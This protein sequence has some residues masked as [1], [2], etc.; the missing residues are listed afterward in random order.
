MTERPWEL[1]KF[2][3]DA[4]TRAIDG[5]D[6]DH[7]P[8]YQAELTRIEQDCDARYARGQELI[9]ETSVED[10]ERCRRLYREKNGQYGADT[11]CE[12]LVSRKFI[13]APA[14]FFLLDEMRRLRAAVA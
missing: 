11:L 2:I 7:K 1:K 6:A 3:D 8:T 9:A 13:I 4:Q 14:Y 5:N 12:R 10:L